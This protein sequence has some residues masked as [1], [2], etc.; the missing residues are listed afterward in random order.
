MLGH[1]LSQGIVLEHLQPDRASIELAPVYIV[2]ITRRGIEASLY[3][4]IDGSDVFLFTIYGHSLVQQDMIV[5][6]LVIRQLADGVHPID[7]IIV[8]L[9]HAV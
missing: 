3:R 5:I 6:R 4:G 8:I 2:Q 7:C 9:A 1:L